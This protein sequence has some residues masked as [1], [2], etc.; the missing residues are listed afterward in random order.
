MH[1]VG[2]RRLGALPTATGG[3]AR[4]AYARARQ[5]G[6]ATAPLLRKAALSE[7][8]I[9]D[10]DA[11]ITVRA[12]IRF[13]N[14]VA[15]ALSDDLLGFH[16]GQTVELRELG[17]LYY[18]AASSETIDEVLQR[19]ARYSSI[20]NEGLAPTYRAGQEVR[21]R[22][23]YV[24]VARHTDRH[25]IEFF[26]MVLLRMCRQ[27]SGVRV[28]PSRLRLTHRRGSERGK[29]AAYFGRRIEFAARVDELAFSAR[30]AA[31]AVVTADPYLNKLL[32]ANCE[33]ALARRP[34]SRGSFRAAA[35]NAM[36]PL[37]PHGNARAAHIAHRLGMSQRT[38][39]RRL[40]AEGLTFSEVRE[41]LR[42]DLARQYL[43]DP[44]LSISRISWLL[45]YREVSAF[46]HAYKR[47]TGRTP[48]DSR[49]TDS[50]APVRSQR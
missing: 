31:L 1:E 28:V 14:L 19:A 25:Q 50:P 34:M 26:M 39:A 24:G 18:V 11:R 33:E 12:Q 3:I 41:D 20:A 8:Q 4:L 9:A 22:F 10:P 45:G 16:L 7:Q 29:L 46:T 35:E 27:L 49:L 47:W 23:G 2:T 36:V 37:L 38:A 17:L 30:T 42:R 32:V 44:Q 13:L 6:I 5:A 48:R 21:V 40:A 15:A 43:A